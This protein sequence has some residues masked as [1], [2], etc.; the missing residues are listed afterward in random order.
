MALLFF[1]NPRLSF[2]FLIK[3]DEK[4]CQKKPF[5]NIIVLSHL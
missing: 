1:I 3:L 5:Q 4:H 2:N